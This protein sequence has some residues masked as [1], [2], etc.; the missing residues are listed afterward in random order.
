MRA[1]LTGCLTLFVKKS[2]MHPVLKNTP[3][4]LEIT[5]RRKGSKSCCFFESFG[6]C[7]LMSFSIARAKICLAVK[8]WSTG[9]LLIVRHCRVLRLM[10]IKIYFTNAASA[11]QTKTPA[12]FIGKI[13]IPLCNQSTPLRLRFCFVKH[14]PCEHHETTVP[15]CRVYDISAIGLYFIAVPTCK[16]VTGCCRI[17]RRF[18]PPISLPWKISVNQYLAIILPLGARLNT[19]AWNPRCLRK[20]GQGVRPSSASA[21]RRRLSP[22]Q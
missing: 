15:G 12:F 17:C 19:Q 2:G 9:Y 16:T 22:G 5:R 11:Q 14:A 7:G 20:N 8:Q 10:K 4:G 1:A 18:Y 21:T 6:K 13:L 3:A